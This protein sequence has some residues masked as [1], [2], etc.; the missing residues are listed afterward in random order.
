MK[1]CRDWFRGRFFVMVTKSDS[2]IDIFIQ[3]IPKKRRIFSNDGED[4]HIFLLGGNGCYSDFR[5]A[6]F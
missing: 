2:L 4:I 1:T 5:Y 6:L 3:K